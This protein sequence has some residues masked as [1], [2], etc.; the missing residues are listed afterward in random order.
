MSAASRVAFGS[1]ARRPRPVVPDQARQLAASL[2][3]Q[4]ERDVEIVRRLNDAQRRLREAN[5]RLWSGLAPDAFGLIYDGTAPPGQSPI[6]ALL[7]DTT[8]AGG[9]DSR[10]TVLRALQATHWQVHRA[11]C[12]YQSAC[13]ER[14]Q[15]A[16]EVGELSQQLTE[17]LI[18]A[19]WTAQDAR[20]ADVHRLARTGELLA[21]QDAEHP[22]N[23]DWTDKR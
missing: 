7:A 15:L 9:R 3:A 11:F 20:D 19:G 4:F 13:E 10:T 2:S 22:T 16:V 18:R 17:A 8:G 5:E 12:A 1:A 23:P 14:R 21:D 6:A